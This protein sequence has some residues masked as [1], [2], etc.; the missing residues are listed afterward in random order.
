MHMMTCQVV[1]LGQNTRG[2]TPRYPHGRLSVVKHRHP[3]PPQP[4]TAMPPP[5]PHCSYK[6]FLRW[7]ENLRRVAAH[8]MLAYVRCGGLLAKRTP[9]TFL[10]SRAR[11]CLH[12]LEMSR[13]A[14]LRKDLEQSLVANTVWAKPWQALNSLKTWWNKIVLSDPMNTCQ[15]RNSYL[16]LP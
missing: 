11:W 3:P 16:I 1:V 4:Q 14:W 15:A 12:Q 7:W 2:V 9:R 8:P 13:P 5:P 10:Q 6:C